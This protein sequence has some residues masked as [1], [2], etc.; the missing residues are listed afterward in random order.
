MSEYTLDQL[1]TQ[2]ER[3][4][5]ELKEA[6]TSIETARAIKKI[7][8]EHKLHIDEAGRLA[9]ETGLVMFGLTRPYLFP[10]R[11]ARALNVDKN[12]AA[13]IAQAVNDQIF[14]P[15]Q[16]YLKNPRFLNL[17]CQ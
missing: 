15:I 17:L 9:D 16:E 14:A 3:L 1:N 7:S 10:V 5:E 2:F 12:K 6:I 4:P 11:V 8:D 13:I